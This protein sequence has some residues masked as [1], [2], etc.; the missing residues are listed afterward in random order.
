[1]KP[2]HRRVVTPM[3]SKGVP[4]QQV[5]AS[6]VDF[7]GKKLAKGRGRRNRLVLLA[8]A[9]TDRLVANFLKPFVES[10]VLVLFP[11]EPAV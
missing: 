11:L 9:P 7:E 4:W 6:S 5:G 3:A 2:C 8:A 10:I 1:M